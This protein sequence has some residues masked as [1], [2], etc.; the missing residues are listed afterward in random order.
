MGIQITLC[1]DIQASKVLEVDQAVIS[2]AQQTVEQ[3]KSLVATAAAYQMIINHQGA[4][5]ADRA[6]AVGKMREAFANNQIALPKSVD[7]Q[8]CVVMAK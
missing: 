4:S 5:A 2:S 3:V 7:E 1:K 8:L 6:M